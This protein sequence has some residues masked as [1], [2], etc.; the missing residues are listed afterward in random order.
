MLVGDVQRSIPL[1]SS[2][3]SGKVTMALFKR[4]DTLP[5]IR[6]KG[7]LPSTYITAF[8][9]GDM[10]YSGTADIY[11]LNE[12]DTAAQ[13]P[14]TLMER[15]PLDPST[16]RLRVVNLVQ[17]GAGICAHF[18]EDDSLCLPYRS[19]SHQH[20]DYV[21]SKAEKIEIEWEGRSEVESPAMRRDTL[22]TLFFTGSAPADRT[23]S[24]TL[25]MPLA[26]DVAAGTT[27]LRILNASY[28][29]GVD[30]FQLSLGDSSY[31][32]TV[33]FNK[34]TE[35]MSVP[36]GIA[37]VRVYRK[38]TTE[39]WHQA[40]GTIPGES[41]ATLILSGAG[42]SLG[43]DLLIDSDPDDQSPLIR[44]TSTS[45]VPLTALAEPVLRIVPNPADD[46][47]TLA[48]ELDRAESIR[49]EVFDAQGS[50]VLSSAA[51]LEGGEHDLIIETSSLPVGIY[52][53]VVRGASMYAVRQLVVVR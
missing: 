11:L 7:T 28:G 23:S 24:K 45:T 33:A 31:V 44:F 15:L 38:G 5:R 13:K 34:E 3:A 2:V 21:G 42:S 47:A 25:L 30:G 48:L 20:E 49:L 37:D 8:L 1:Y 36:A 29:T 39:P 51:Q 14:M 35:Y 32:R 18:A 12:T 16:G 27:M 9:S 46:R 10:N 50:R 6:V 41:Y 22:T 4:G 17:G 40:R 53:V 26:G 19:A 52:S 43:I